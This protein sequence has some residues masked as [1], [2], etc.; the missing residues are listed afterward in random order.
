M[1]AVCA[2]VLA[3]TNQE[4]SGQAG[5]VDAQVFSAVCMM[6]DAAAQAQR[7][8]EQANTEAKNELLLAIASGEKTFADL[9]DIGPLATA[10]GLTE[11]DLAAG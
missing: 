3:M 9:E 4:D 2:T 8:L 10:I 5:R 6:A 11:D 1:P 7:A